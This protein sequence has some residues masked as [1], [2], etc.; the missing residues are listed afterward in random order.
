MHKTRHIIVYQVH[1]TMDILGFSYDWSIKMKLGDGSC[2][3]YLR[4]GPPALRGPSAGCPRMEIIPHS[5]YWDM[6]INFRLCAV[7]RNPRKS[8][9]KKTKK[10]TENSIFL[11]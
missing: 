11:I 10:L 1:C 5:S 3:T 6:Q 9:G 4:G 8:W 7:T 2:T